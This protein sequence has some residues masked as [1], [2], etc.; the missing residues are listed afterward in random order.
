MD[1]STRSRRVLA[2]AV[3]LPPAGEER[4][5]RCRRGWARGD[6]LDVFRRRLQD[7]RSTVCSPT[8][9]REAALAAGVDQSQ[10]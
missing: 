8:P 6:R 10:Y 4:R 9:V 2:P 3:G 7:A 5:R 1:A